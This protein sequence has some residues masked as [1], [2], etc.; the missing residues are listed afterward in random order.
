MHR[1]GRTRAAAAVVAIL[2]LIT[3]CSSDSKSSSTSSGTSGS[4]ASSGSQSDVLGPVQQASGQPIKIG[5][6]VDGKGPQ[7][8]NQVEIDAAN[9]T[10]KFLNEHRGGFA[11]RPIQLD[12]CDAQLDPAKTTD[13]ANQMVQANVPAVLMGTHSNQLQSWQ[14]LHQA[15]IPMMWGATNEPS[16]LKDTQTSFVMANAEA[17]LV[18]LPI[19]VAKEHNLH[20]VTVIL[21]DVP[22][23][24]SS[25]EPVP[26]AFKEAGIEV[27]V[28]PVPIG[29]ADM[30]APLQSLTGVSDSVAH[31]VGFDAFCIAAFNAFQALN[32]TGP[33]SGNNLC[34]TDATRT[35]ISGSYLKGISLVSGVPAGVEDST[36]ELY[37]AVVA[38]YAPSIDAK[39]T[40]G[41]TSFM[42]LSGMEAVVDTITGDIT[43]GSIINALKSMKS[44]EL[45]GSGGLHFRCN[46]KAVADSPALCV[47]GALKTVLDDKGEPASFTP[48]GDTPIED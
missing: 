8:D 47:R 9:A 32:F 46:G 30:T 5:M 40:A 35:A 10:V 3:A 33:I 16:I 19:A 23:A 36:T 27:Q 21:V 25:Y 17:A 15:G 1:P 13:C 29:T 37:R 20:K 38:K 28:V 12:V 42:V 2:T 44:M 39:Q 4:S 18:D 24:R 22:A 6:I 11:G 41:A 26:Q 7:T 14:V 34:V 43:P 45:P 31:I 48:I